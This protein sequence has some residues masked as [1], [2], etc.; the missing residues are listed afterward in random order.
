MID[1]MK[2]ELAVDYS[3]KRLATLYKKGPCHE[4]LYLH[5]TTL[6]RPLFHGLKPC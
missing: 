3:D 5:Q 1:H 4:T 6:P 2:Y